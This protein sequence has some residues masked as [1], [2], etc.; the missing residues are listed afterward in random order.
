M[1]SLTLSASLRLPKVGVS[2]V[3]L[4]M[5]LIHPPRQRDEFLLLAWLGT[6]RVEGGARKGLQ[7]QVFGTSVS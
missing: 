4:G 5:V 7:A 3:S 6:N 2:A 1:R